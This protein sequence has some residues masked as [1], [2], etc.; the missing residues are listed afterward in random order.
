VTDAPQR[1][2]AVAELLATI[3]PGSRA[4]IAPSH[5]L[6]ARDTDVA[7]PTTPAASPATPKS[8]AREFLVLPSRTRPRLLVPADL[9]RADRSHV[10]RAA[11]QRVSAVDGRREV[12]ARR[13]VGVLASGPL[14]PL[15]F[16]TTA[17]VAPVDDRSVEAYLA[18]VV[19]CELRLSVQVGAE[20]ANA[21]PVLGVY[22]AAGGVELGFAKVGSSALAGRLVASESATL[23]RLAAV[24]LSALEIPPVLHTGRW[25]G[26]EVLLLAT[27]RGSRGA[28]RGLP[29]DAMREVATVGGTHDVLLRD[30]PW[31]RSLRARITVAGGMHADSLNTLLDALVSRD[32]DRRLTHGTWH[33]DW[34]PWNMAW[35]GARPVVWD[36]ERC[37]DEV[38][39][40]FDAV[41]F[42]AHQQ[43]RR[44]D[45]MGVALDAL[46]GRAGTAVAA[47][48]APW[49]PAPDRDIAARAV[50]DAYLLEIA[51]RFAGDAAEVA[52]A[53]VERLA[54]WY[55]RVA[56]ERL[57]VR[58]GVP[59]LQVRE[60]AEP[61]G[62]RV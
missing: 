57:A 29:Y 61:P 19:G 49:V 39:V 42:V 17:R 31:V 47:L 15:L 62:R 13:G 20:R 27:V 58:P 38:P 1:L 40:G 35:S 7:S 10:I 50:V 43:L 37:A 46:T 9:P 34:G 16:S 2:R 30:S 59:P 8:T 18:R 24:R 44:V 21:K 12:A 26:A 45:E 32:G 5:R 4:V 54:T 53:P 3:Y 23:T 48:L 51:C 41:H 55:L 36:W 28:D 6:R 56:A 60:T 33:G 25:Q 52:T 11:L 22:R 14:G